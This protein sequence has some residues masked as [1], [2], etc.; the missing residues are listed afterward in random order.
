M[1]IGAQI[2]VILAILASVSFSSFASDLDSLF[3]R[4]KGTT[5]E[6]R[7]DSAGMAFYGLPY[8]DA[9]L[10][11]GPSSRFDQGPL[12]RFDAFD[13]TTYVETVL[14][15]AT[16][17][18]A[19]EFE[20]RLIRIRYRDGRVSF[21]DRNH[22]PCVDWIAQNTHSGLL[23]DITT[24]IGKPWGTAV[25]SAK[26]TKKQWFEKLPLSVIRV[27]G[28][29]DSEREKRLAELHAAGAKFA[30]VSSEVPYIVLEKIIT[31]KE[32]VP[33]ELARRK[34]EEAELAARLRTEE[35]R[36]PQGET[37]PLEKK[38]HDEL[39]DKRLRYLIQDVEVNPLFLKAIPTATVLNIV[40]PGFSVPGSAMNISHQGFVIQKKE[41]TFFRHVSRSGA[42]AK[43]VPLAHY[44]RL[45]LLSPAIRGVQLLRVNEVK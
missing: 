27:E 36:A 1:Q 16:A 31:R 42:R 43:D 37:T 14:A 32:V 3:A 21:V 18:K 34:A 41:G 5:I 40:R 25:A 26:I 13:C 29:S 12:Y 8:M 22:F 17:K 33:E 9:P 20:K 35:E 38:I 7:I 24:E 23:T 28:L 44:L 11:D 39:I 10:G 30:P 4:V 2:S 45:C 6:E 19:S 15:L